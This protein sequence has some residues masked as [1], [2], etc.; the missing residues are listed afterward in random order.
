[1]GTSIHGHEVMKMM[2][3]SKES[4]TKDSLC[5]AID[6]QYG[7]NAR[8][9]TCSAKNLSARELVDFLET[10]G[11]FISSDH[12]FTTHADKMCHHR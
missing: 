4:Y 12:G 8:F 1:M 11:K 6:H 9:H 7:H 5:S 3:N 2:L 10:K